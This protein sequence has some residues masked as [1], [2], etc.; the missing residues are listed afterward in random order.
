M[1]III[2][3]ALLGLIA[4]M[5]SCT[6]VESGAEKAFSNA[7]SALKPESNEIWWLPPEDKQDAAESDPDA[8]LPKDT[9]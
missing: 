5:A 6:G 7:N 3:I 1:R 9:K 8:R 4:L 2:K